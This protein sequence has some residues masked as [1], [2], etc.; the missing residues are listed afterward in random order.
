MFLCPIRRRYLQMVTFQVTKN[1]FY[2]SV[3]SLVIQRLIGQ[4]KSDEL[5]IITRIL[6]GATD[7]YAYFLDTYGQ[8]VFNLI[9]R[10]VSS[11]EDAEEL[12]QDTFM[13]AFEHLQ[14]F[15]GNS[16]FSTWIY[17]IAYNTALTA[18]RKKD[19]EVLSIDDRLWSNLS[20]TEVDDALDDDSEEQIAKLQ[21]ALDRLSPDERALITFFYEENKPVSEI[22]HILNQAEGNIKVKLHRLRKKL[23]ILMQE[24]N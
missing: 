21:H 4:M 19:A 24:D 1:F 20:D 11:P 2:F 13:K 10:M 12:T 16:S 5:H 22:A 6:N 3:T 15:N 14:S 9:V 8:Q 23:Y 17:R 18:L 7:E